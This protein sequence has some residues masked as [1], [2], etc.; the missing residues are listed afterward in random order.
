MFIGYRKAPPDSKRFPKRPRPLIGGEFRSRF[1]LFAFT[2]TTGSLALF[3]IPLCLFLYQN[4]TSFKNLAFDLHPQIITNLEQETFWLMLF[5]FVSCI[6]LISLVV[7]W[8]YQMTHE[9]TSPLHRVQDHMLK[10]IQGNLSEP[11]E[12]KE[13]EVLADYIKGYE[14]LIEFFQI[15]YRMELEYLR[16]LHVDPQNRDAYKAWRNLIDLKEQRLGMKK[17]K[18][19][20]VISNDEEFV[21]ADSGRRAS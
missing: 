5:A 19:L 3:F 13:K 9:L 4:Y 21:E 2:A 17:P 15:E 1:V 16:R 10:V 20:Y 14:A 12:S 11:L 8:T 18:E 6:S 7:F